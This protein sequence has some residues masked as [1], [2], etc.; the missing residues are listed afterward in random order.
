[1]DVGHGSELDFR[2]FPLNFSLKDLFDEFR[3]ESWSH[4]DFFICN[5]PLE[6]EEH[7]QPVRLIDLVMKLESSEYVKIVPR[8]ES[9]ELSVEAIIPEKDEEDEGEEKGSVL[10]NAITP[11]CDVFHGDLRL[12]EDA[13]IRDALNFVKPLFQHDDRSLFLIEDSNDHILDPDQLIKDVPAAEGQRDLFV[14]EAV[15]YCIESRIDGF[16]AQSILLRKGRM[17]TVGDFKKLLSVDGQFCG[18]DGI[19]CKDDMIVSRNSKLVIVDGDQVKRME[20]KLLDGIVR[21]YDVDG[22]ATLS[23]FH[24]AIELDCD[25]SFVLMNEG[26][27]A[28][29]DS[30]VVKDIDGLV[31]C[32]Q[33]DEIVLGATAAN[34]EE[35]IDIRFEM[36]GRKFCVKVPKQENIGYAAERIGEHYKVTKDRVTVVFAGRT[37]SP[38]MLVSNLPIKEETRFGVYVQLDYRL[39]IQSLIGM[40]S[41]VGSE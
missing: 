11:P 19:V 28:L 14:H 29:D 2:T 16:E 1:M 27:E 13:T 12:S 41:T 10:F 18:R 37:L 21:S 4:L 38:N 9:E 8:T 24:H 22:D 39:F 32:F 40:Q 6:C 3:S 30:L 5:R 17:Y 15:S 25:G 31:T 7:G 34:N 26:G 23:D 35:T 33:P 20:V 36:E